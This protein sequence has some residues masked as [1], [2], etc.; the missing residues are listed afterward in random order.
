MTVLQQQ[1]K[2][3]MV[4]RVE[5][6]SL[7]MGDEPV[8]L[9]L[10]LRQGFFLLSLSS[11]FRSLHSKAMRHRSVCK[12]VRVQRSFQEDLYYSLYLDNG[13]GPFFLCQTCGAQAVVAP[14]EYSFFEKI[15]VWVLI[16]KKERKKK[17]LV[18]RYEQIYV[19]YFFCKFYMHLT[20][21]GIE[22]MQEHYWQIAS[23]FLPLSF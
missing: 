1:F 5:H 18:L 4:V 9:H 17:M 19:L 16:H 11:S 22:A 14:R 13:P 23:L 7:K 2:A 21:A 6:Y 20:P 15:W 8:R 10:N 3:V 12:C